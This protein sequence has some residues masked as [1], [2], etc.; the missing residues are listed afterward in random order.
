MHVV[1]ETADTKS[2]ALE[3]PPSLRDLFAYQAGQ[4]CTFR[5][6][7]GD[8]E[9]LRC[10]SMSSAPEIDETMCVTVK[11]V[12][13]GVVSN[14][15]HDNLEPG[16]A[17]D[18]GVPTGRFCLGAGGRDVVAFGAGSGIT[19]ILA[20]VK[21]ALATTARSVHLYYANRDQG[22]VIF[23]DE[24]DTLARKYPDRLAV[25]HH[26]DAEE[27][28]VRGD[29]VRAWLGGRTGADYYVCGPG[30]FMDVVEGA[31]VEEGVDAADI[32][33]E[34]FTP[35][36]AAPGP[37]AGPPGGVGNPQVTIELRGRGATAEHRPGTT[38]I[39]VARELGMS[40][41]SSCEAGSCAT[42]MARL[43]EGE[44]AMRTNNVLTP[45][46]VAEGWILTC[47]AVPT[48]SSV[49]IVYD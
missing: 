7:I 49:R 24:L 29:D 47:Q 2:F 9:H 43:V 44:V 31:L 8:V 22:A 18:T 11:R 10:Y 38:V 42:C 14:W 13:G 40:P 1:Q 26:L 19:P 20:I 46:E 25:R 16:D 32:R 21:T 17:I 5:V 28:L 34:R 3:V 4:F 35:T 41:P 12:P 37:G 6:V 15:M 39:Q 30:P 33:I 23:A 48:S 45:E 27:G 36:D